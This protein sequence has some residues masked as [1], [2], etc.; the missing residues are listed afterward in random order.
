MSKIYIKTTFELLGLQI[1]FSILAMVF[2][3]N[4]SWMDNWA[5]VFSLLTAWLFLGAVH[6]T[7][8]QMGHKDSKNNVIANNHL[9]P[10]QP[11][12]KLNRLKGARIGLPFF[13]INIVIVLITMIFDSGNDGN[14]G[15]LFIIHRIMLGPVFGFIPDGKAYWH[16]CYVLCIIMYIPC[17]TAYVSGTYH[18]SLTERIVPRLIYKS[19]DKKD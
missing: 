8:W 13:V 2:S 16:V 17:I 6:S 19:T 9:L 11:E 14:G 12:I 15:L 3:T 7:F 10:G 1:F 5:V 18:F 4:F